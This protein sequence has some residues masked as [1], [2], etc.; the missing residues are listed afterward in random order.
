MSIGT[1]VW[2]GANAHNF[3]R[4]KSETAKKDA[5]LDLLFSSFFFFVFDMVNGICKYKR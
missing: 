2:G 4:K 3:A 5:R 1:P